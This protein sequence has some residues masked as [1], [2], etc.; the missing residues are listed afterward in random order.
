MSYADVNGLSL[1]YAEH[2]CGEPL[3]LL[4]GG[5][6]TGEMFGPVLPALAA[7]RRVIAVD[8]QA[9]GR[10]ADVGR[11]LRYETM[12]DD[13][14]ALIGYLGLVRSDVMGVSMGGG[15]ALRTAIQHPE[16]VDR[17]VLVSV[18]FRRDGW[19]PEI[20]AAMRQFTPE[21]GEAMKQSP[22]YATYARVAPRPGDWPVLHAKMG[23][24]LSA[25]YDWSSEVAAITA[26]TMLVYADSDSIRP[27]HMVEFFALLGGGLRDADWDGSGRPAGRLAIM[28]GTTHYDIFASPALAAPILEFLAAPT[29]G[30]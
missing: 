8:L 6:G 27:A 3:V 9:H 20:G 10:T 29:P 2:G 12:A 13:V 19:F 16:A 25:D 18:P 17:V 28:P 30:L 7:Q 4:H 14:A 1:Y 5:F 15:V 23:E 24:L 21:H 11:P 26:P 22:L